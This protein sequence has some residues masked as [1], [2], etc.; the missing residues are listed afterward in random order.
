[1]HWESHPNFTR[2]EFACSHSGK[3]EM[4][5]DFMERLQ[6]LRQYCGF[7]FVI[8]S[9]YRDATHPI[10]AKKDKPGYHAQGI[11]CDIAVFANMAYRVV[12]AAP[13]FGFTGIGV[14]QRSGQPR[15]IHLDTR[16][17]GPVLYSY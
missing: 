11:A 7:P 1:M 8:T 4:D 5:P 17:G 12:T 10:E 15:F 3:C 13:R 2:D 14:S 9:G 16:K 6:L